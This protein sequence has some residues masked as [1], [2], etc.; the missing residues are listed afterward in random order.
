MFFSTKWYPLRLKHALEHG[1]RDKAGTGQVANREGTAQALIALFAREG[2]KRAEPAVL[3][4]ADLF[5]D[6][7]GEDIRRRLFVTQG[8][9][10]EELCLRPE[11]TIP[12]CREYLA[13]SPGGGLAALSYC[14]PV[15][16]QR[17]GEAGESPQAGIES[18]GRD[19]REAAD[20]EVLAL[21][22]EAVAMLGLAAPAV[23]L[24]D[25]ALIDRLVTTLG[26]AAPVRRRLL[27]GIASGEGLAA[28]DTGEAGNGKA[29]Q[30]HA[31]L[32]AAIEGQD[33]TAARAF[34]ED[35]L[36]I[37]GISRV[38]GRSAAE[39]AERFLD[40]AA[41]R[42][43]RLAGEARNII[44]RF[45]AITGDP[46]R[47]ALAL[48]GLA[49]EAGL[50]LDAVIDAFEAR[51][52]FMAA[53]GLGVAGFH[54]SARFARSLDY[55]TGFIFELHD[56]ARPG[57][58]PVGGGGRYDGLLGHLGAGRVIPAVGCSIWLDRV[59]GGAAR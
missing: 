3:Q 56:P 59:N 10:G 36:A 45:L 43:G 40:R 35:V 39:I 58:K 55:Y 42:A 41:Q 57:A 44:A 30:D 49:S 19:D 13:G 18:L 48:R 20:A 17:P 34:V 9:E 26:L 7:S 28:L 12:V 52:G 31:G 14:G 46:D 6:L 47:A 51:I 5:L 1:C 27:R 22:L 21:A 2:Y 23:T 25:M 33:P 29:G 53:R 37:A 38:G 32:L 54:F 15:F 24:G 4:P 11:Y 50:D 16:R 8:P